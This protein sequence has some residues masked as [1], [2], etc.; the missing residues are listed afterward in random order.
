MKII[1]T[2]MICL[3]N[4]FVY[5]CAAPPEEEYVLH[6]E[7]TDMSVYKYLDD[8]DHAFIQIKF[9]EVFR[10]FD[11]QLDGVVLLSYPACPYCNLAVPILNEAAKEMNLKVYYLDIY[12]DDFMELNTAQRL[13]TVN[14][15]KIYIE[16]ALTQVPGKDKK[17]LYVPLVIAVSAGEIIDYHISLTDDFRLKDGLNDRQKKELK[18]IYRQLLKTYVNRK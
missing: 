9:D 12:G 8:E 17:D 6:S 16:P 2:A 13:A 15:L 18:D 5:G 14:R 7:G 3:I 1:L 10:L 11:E 4:L